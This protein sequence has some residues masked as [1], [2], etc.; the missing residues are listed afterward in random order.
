LGAVSAGGIGSPELELTHSGGGPSAFVASQSGGNWG[1]V[2]PSKFSVLVRANQQSGQGNGVGVGPAT[3]RIS[4]IRRASSSAEFDSVRAGS[5]DDPIA[6]TTAMLAATI[7]KQPRRRRNR[8]D[9][10]VPFG[11]EIIEALE[12]LLYPKPQESVNT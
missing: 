1:G 12:A 10:L 2:N 3:A 5:R 11:L 4:F 7:T 8:D 6:P 9:P